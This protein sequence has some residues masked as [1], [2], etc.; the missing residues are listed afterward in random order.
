MYLWIKIIYFQNGYA[1]CI[2][3][4]VSSSFVTLWT[5]AGQ[6]PLSMGS[7]RQEYWSGLPCTLPRDHP[8]P[9][10]EPMSLTSPALAGGLFTS[11]TTWEAQLLTLRIG[12][13]L[14]LLR[15][16]HHD[17]R[18]KVKGP[19]PH[20]HIGRF[21]LLTVSLSYIRYVTYYQLCG[22]SWSLNFNS[23]NQG[24]GARL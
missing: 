11:H 1:C 15:I 7:S 12:F 13:S 16:S 3:S 24:S 17:G 18:R 19:L 9:K 6:T 20:P 8:D 21:C 10:M 22:S 23:G 2:T 14:L 4:V 5:V